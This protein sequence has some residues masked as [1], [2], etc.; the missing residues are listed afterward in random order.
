MLQNHDCKLHAYVL[1]TNHVHL[2]LTPTKADLIPR[3][4][5]SI[6]RRY[7][8]Y[9]NRTHHRTCTIW[10]NRYK[11]SVVHADSYLLACQRYMNPMPFVLPWWTTPHTINGAA[12]DTMRSASQTHASRRIGCMH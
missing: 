1:M 3:L 5:M 7:V 2:L 8:Q 12:I 4:V 9:I 6:G 11:A 10:D